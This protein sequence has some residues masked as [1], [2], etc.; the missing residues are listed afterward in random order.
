MKLSPDKM[1]NTSTFTNFKKKNET[2]HLAMKLVKGV[3]GAKVRII[4][5]SFQKSTVVHNVT[6]EGVLD[7]NLENV[8]IY[9]VL[10]VVPDRNNRIV[11]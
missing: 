3:V 2:V 11:W 6:R 10:E 4:A 1:P 9:S 7:L 5:K 8:V